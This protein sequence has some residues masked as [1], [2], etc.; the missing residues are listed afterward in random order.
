MGS[1]TEIGR[2]VVAF[3]GSAPSQAALRVAV[4]EATSRQTPLHLVSAIDVLA[5]PTP[6]DAV[7]S[8]TARQ[9]AHEATEWAVTLLGRDRVTTTIEAGS[10]TV[11]VLASCRP[12]DL[13]VVGSQGHRPVARMFL[14][15]TSAALI[16]L[17]T[18]PVIVVKGTMARVHGPVLVGVD[19]SKPSG[20]AVMFAAEEAYRRGVTLRVVFAVSPVVDAMGFVSGPDE[21]VLREAA[22]V[23]GEA[24]AEAADTYPGLV[25]DDLLVQ[26]HPVEALT[27]HANGAQLLVV[28]TRGR[29]GVLSML[30]GSVGREMIQRAPCPVVVVPPIPAVA[31]APDGTGGL[32]PVRV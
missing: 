19:G 11:V 27:R 31:G 26:A 23:L 9:A 2:V 22:T 32:R 18:C 3:D 12:D 24:V 20:E 29:G 5:N 28:G 1:P 6:S 17:A 14:G 7:Y 4:S 15:S 10:P 8:R 21:P 16:T 30:L 25:V 13:L